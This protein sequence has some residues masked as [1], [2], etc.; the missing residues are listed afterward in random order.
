M[1][2]KEILSL[3]ELNQIIRSVIDISFPETFLVIAEIA[4]FDVKNH[5]YLTLVDKHE[6]IIRAEMKAVIWAD[7][8]EE[9]SHEFKR[10][11]GIELK[12]GIKILFEAS[13]N[14]HERYGLKLHILNIDPSYTVGELSLRRR[15]ILERLA[16]EGLKDRNKR[17]EFPLVPQRIGII[18]SAT[19]AGYEDLV[20]H[21]KNN[22]YGYKYTCRLYEALMQ[23]DRAEAS[24]I[25]ALARC[26]EDAPLLDIVVI[27]RGGGGE[28]ELHCFDSYEIGK[29]IAYMPLPVISGIGHERDITVVDEVS[30]IRVKT[31]TAV[32]D[33]IITRT[34][35]FED[36]IDSLAHSLVYQTGRLT[37]D[38]KERL[39][40]IT[41]SLEGTIRN[42]LSSNVHRLKTFI[43]GLQYSL[44]F[45]QNQTQ[46]LKAMESNINHLNPLNVLK[47]GY[48]ITYVNDRV[49]KSVSEIEIG[50]NL[51]TVLHRGEV[52][53]KVERK[54]LINSGGRGEGQSWL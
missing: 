46:R 3:Y 33:L 1:I 43:K 29:S 39:S 51:R 8:Y 30:N 25:N 37:S 52:F 53:S 5:C 2:Q 45:I 14:F 12:K 22:A 47:R 28:S 54:K 35:E 19:A 44:R 21:L 48:S 15:E 32:A 4:S 26:A 31:P 49:V 41:R 20:T 23:G 38:L 16:R 9:L 27:V 18:S 24:I 34:K 10:A 6:D 17:L 13:V 7:R 36:R 42:V 11:T 50:D 40:Y